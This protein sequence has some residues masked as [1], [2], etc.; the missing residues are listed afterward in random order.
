[1]PYGKRYLIH[2]IPGDPD[3]IGTSF[4]FIQVGSNFNASDGLIFIIFSYYKNSKIP[5]TIQTLITIEPKNSFHTNLF[6]A[7]IVITI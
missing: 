2:Q 6:S 3:S 1:M 5:I 7:L 4:C